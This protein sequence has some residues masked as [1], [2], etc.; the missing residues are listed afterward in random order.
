ME[1]GGVADEK[2]RAVMDD[3]KVGWGVGIPTYLHYT[4]VITI[5]TK[6]EVLSP[7]ELRAPEPPSAAQGDETV[8]ML[9]VAP[10]CCT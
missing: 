6:V 4:R 3:T 1:A 5:R 2:P 7:P 8:V 9:S 10:C